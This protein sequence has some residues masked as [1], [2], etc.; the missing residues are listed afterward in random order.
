MKKIALIASI[1]FSSVVAAKT[2]YVAPTGGSDYN[3]G[4]NINAPWATWQHAFETAIAGDTVYFRGGVWY[5]SKAAYGNNITYISP[6]ISIGHNG[7][8]GM[9]ICFFNYPGET[10]ILDC[11]NVHTTGSFNTGLQIDDAH[12]INWKGLTIRNV[13]QREADIEAGGISGG[14][15]SNMH[16]EN[17]TLHNIGGHGWY[18]ESDVGSE[19]RSY[20]LGWDGS[21]YIPY[22]TTTFINCDAY[23]CVDT[24]RV[25]PVNHAGNMGDGFKHING[26]AYVTFDGCRAWHC[27]DDGFDMPGFGETRLNNCWSFANGVPNYAFEGNGFKFGANDRPAPSP[28]RILTNCLAAYNVDGEGFF[29]LEYA[30]Y[31]RNNSRLY[32]CVSYKNE[33]GFVISNNATYPNSE[34]IYKNNIV[35]KSIGLDAG[36]RPL[37]LDVMCL[38]T[39]S[40]NNW[41]YA[42]PG[43]LPRWVYATDVTVTDDDFVSLDQAELFLPRKSDGSLPDINFL[44][45]KSTSDLIDK[46]IDVG[47]PFY[48]NAPDLGYSEYLSGS[49]VPAAP[50]V[51]SAAI[52]NATPSRMDITYNLTLANIIPAASAFTVTVNSSVRTVSSVAISGTK[53]LLTLA[54]P[55]V[56]GNVV[57]VAYTKPATNPLQTSAGGQAASFTARSV[58]NNVA[59]VNPVYVSSVVENATPGRLDITYNLTLA[60][61]VPAASAFTVTVNSSVRTVSS[62]AIS[63]TKVLLTLASPVVYGNVVTVAYT[64]PATNP[65]QTSAGGQAVSFTAKSV[66]NNC[67]LTP[68]LPPVITIT[69]PTKSLTFISPATITIEAAASDPD[70]SIAKVEYYNGSTLLGERTLSPY[71]FTWKDVLEGT[72]TITAVASDNLNA[73]TVSA[74]VT[75]VIEKSAEVINQLPVVTITSPGKSGKYKKHDN[76]VIV[77]SATDPD[78]SISKVEL[79]SGDVTVGEATV[80]PYSFILNDVDTGKY[81]LTVIATDNL[82]ATSASSSLELFVELQDEERSAISKLYPNPN[83]GHFSVDISSPLPTAENSVT[84]V[85]LTGKIIYRGLLTE[86]QV[87]EEFDLSGSAAGTYILVLHTG[88]TIVSSRKFVKR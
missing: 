75:V 69:S 67:S 44:K 54:S 59:A 36:D 31:Y 40:N 20:N 56:Y 46:G 70:G 9:P 65:L 45:L 37:E 57:T 83:D 72:Y 77:A 47:I 71:S 13:Y 84:I 79:K 68:N 24:F 42:V 27:S 60:N 43:S 26:G 85:N 17:M 78:G 3:I 23:Q 74:A 15:V 22:D 16:W 1:A 61:I 32:N 80:A 63:G 58:T 64:K 41:D 5:P 29:D 81:V 10:P 87:C 14:A 39:E 19:Y 49:I 86:G 66:I 30:D 52:E 8:P 18:L 88:N 50:V 25:N 53:V 2:Y 76:I 33:S 12:W 4:T 82:G 34:S 7:Q 62:V 48:G 73:K 11:R 51:V 21:G 55:V 28:R 38:Y 35:Y 6:D